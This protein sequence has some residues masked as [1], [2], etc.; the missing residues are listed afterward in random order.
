M[1]ITRLIFI[2][3]AIASLP[4]AGRVQWNGS[5]G[6]NGAI[7][8][9]GS[10]GIGLGVNG[11]NARLHVSG[12]TVLTNTL[13]IG[14]NTQGNATL[15][16]LGNMLTGS[17]NLVGTNSFAG[18]TS[19]NA[20]GTFATGT[21]SFAFGENCQ[22]FGKMPSPWEPVP[23]SPQRIPCPLVGLCRARLLE[24]PSS[25]LGWPVIKRLTTTGRIA[26]WLALIIPITTS[27]H[28]L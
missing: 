26:S 19:S 14:Q 9:S 17:A 12:N 21:T 28:C 3:F 10:V 22:V 11:V 23:M 27:Q 16:V 13:T 2:G 25:V 18:G 20:S 5:N 1:R 6:S 15:H 7:A 24:M 8:R 4:L